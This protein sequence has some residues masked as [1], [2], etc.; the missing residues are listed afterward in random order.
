MVHIAVAKL[1]RT[2]IFRLESGFWCK[3]PKTSPCFWVVKTKTRIG[4]NG[5]FRSFNSFLKLNG[6]VSETTFFCR[7]L[8]AN[9]HDCLP[10]SFFF[11]RFLF[12][13]E[14]FMVYFFSLLFWKK[15]QFVCSG[16]WL[17]FHV[18]VCLFFWGFVLFFVFVCVCVLIV[19]FCSSL[20]ETQKVASPLN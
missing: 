16:N 6:D 14:F 3:A 9:T 10:L 13:F 5:V 12:D 17:L 18:F 1:K 19:S 7:F 2:P 20:Q 8:V 11:S 4:H 15:N